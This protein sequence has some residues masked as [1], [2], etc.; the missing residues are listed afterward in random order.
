MKKLPKGIV[1][2]SLASFFMDVAGEAAF[3]VLPF[4]LTIQLGASAFSLGVIEGIADGTASF[5]KFF[6][7]RI[8]DKI[9][10]R[11]PLV[12][13]GYFM[14]SVTKPLIAFV[15]SWGGV[16]ALRFLDRA[17]KGIRG[18]PRDAWL[19]S[20]VED[21]KDLPRAFGFHRAMDHAGAVTGPVLATTYLYFFNEDYRGLFLWTLL[22][23]LFAAYFIFN[24]KEESL[25]NVKSQ[26]QVN[27]LDSLK[28]VP[29]DL[30][31]YFLILFIFCL[32]NSTDA[33]LLLRL[34][35]AG[36]RTAFVPLC[37]AV[38]H[39]IKMGSSYYSDKVVNKLGIKNT[40]LFGWAI[41]ALVY[42]AFGY[43][44]NPVIIAGVFFSYGFFFGL[45]EGPERAMVGILAPVELR[46]TVFG[47]YNMVS[48]FGVLLA[49]L[50]FGA[51]W[52]TIGFSAAFYAGGLLALLS[53]VL[54][55][56]TARVIDSPT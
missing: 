28:V 30:K 44:N 55:A 35:E 27:I 13:V 26:I 51:L 42:F 29:K 32:G 54:W 50:I 5:L 4:F 16:L 38:L 23:G 56:Q 21:K 17:G 22:P 46:G 7:G 12:F 2:I 25:P 37:W 14:A 11:K 9:G 49:S 3:S 19:T 48:G 53:A 41:Y 47:I 43:L 40:I 18:A 31:K 10:K 24:T 8:S 33:F 1:T 34:K 39:I 36:I 52:S 6:S 15:G 20:I 45:T